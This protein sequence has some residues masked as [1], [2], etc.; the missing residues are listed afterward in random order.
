MATSESFFARYIDKPS[1]T[2]KAQEISPAQRLLDFLQR[3]PKDVISVRNIQQYGPRTIRDLRGAIDAAE[4][5][6]RHGFLNPV[7]KPARRD[8]REW[9]IIRRPTFNPTVAQ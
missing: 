1:P 8:R 3:W 5:L 6:A 4:A 7:Q 9:Q 2:E